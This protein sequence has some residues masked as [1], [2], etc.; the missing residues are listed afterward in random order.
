GHEDPTKEDT[1]LDWN[2][3]AKMPGTKV[4]LMGVERI[5]Q[6][7]E[8]LVAGGMEASTPV[9]MVRW[10]TTGRQRSIEGTLANIA[11]VVVK[12]NF[13]A[14][15]VTIIGG[16]VKL[17][18]KLNWFE[19]RPLFGQRI[20]VTRTREQASQLSREFIE[21]GAEVLEIPTVKIIPPNRL[22]GIVE[23]LG[24]LNAYDWIVFTSPN[25]VSSF[26]EYF[27]KK[28][29]DLREIGGV[30]IAAVGPAT[31]TRLKELHLQVDLMPV[32]YVATRI[33]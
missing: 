10:G 33:A 26:F 7:A 25:G 5:R 18:E 6:L 29:Q 28:F 30:R 1:A 11:D 12:E 13:K 3:I 15:A 22:E 16:V 20:V 17:R 2:L 4:V 14:P 19:Q 23:A 21:R 31:A 27:F 24:G 32:E 9:G 8:S